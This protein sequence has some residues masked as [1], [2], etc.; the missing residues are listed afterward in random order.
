M[1]QPDR[2]EREAAAL[3]AN[4]LKRK[5]QARRRGLEKAPADASPAQNSDICDGAAAAESGGKAN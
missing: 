2:I 5:D 4:L 3:R 1:K